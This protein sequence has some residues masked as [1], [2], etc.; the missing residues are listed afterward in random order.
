[1]VAYWDSSAL[2]M[3]LARAPLAA[4]Y[5]TIA[6]E[7]GIVTWWGTYVECAATISRHARNGSAPSQ[8]AESW[9]LLEEFSQQWREIGANQQLRRA[10]TR[11]ARIHVLPATDSLQLGA[12]LLSCR[13][14]PQ[15]ARFLSEDLRLK[16]AAVSEGFVVD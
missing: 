15:S 8:I 7:V 10:A 9:R 1:M 13:F 12:A 3:I 2:V 11:A 6:R 4:R 5:R 14:E 16:R